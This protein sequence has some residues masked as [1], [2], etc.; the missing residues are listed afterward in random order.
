MNLTDT[1]HVDAT[2]IRLTATAAGAREG[3]R[4][5]LEALR[6]PATTPETAEA[7]LLVVSE[8]VT[9]AL[10][11]GGGTYTLR[12][13]AH[14]DLIEVAVS[15]LSPQPP[16]MRDP[17]LTGATGGFGWRTVTHL[18]RTTAV[19]RRPTGGKTVSAFI[20]R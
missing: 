3:A 14:P 1:M 8:L 9:N 19:I 17:D 11:H 4:N 20:A 16:H 13:T 6:D 15:D 10:R 5:F 12:L 18:A 2:A 7:V